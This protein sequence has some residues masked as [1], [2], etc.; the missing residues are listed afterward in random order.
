MEAEERQNRSRA[1]RTQE[2][3][4]RNL[5]TEIQTLEAK[6]AELVAELEKPETYE[7]PGRAQ[8]INRELLDVQHRLA[9]LNPEW[10]E[11]AT[12]LAEMA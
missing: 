6:Q 3:R 10:E 12:K 4:V 11:A 5:E 2:Q 1:R 9:A 7:A 8:Q